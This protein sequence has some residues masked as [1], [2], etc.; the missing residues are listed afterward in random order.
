MKHAKKI[1]TKVATRKT[2]K[3]DAKKLYNALIQKDIDTLEREKSN[4][5]E[6]YNILNI[7]E[8]VGSIFNGAYL[9]YKN[10][11]K[12]TIFSEYCREVLQRKQN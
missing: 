5:F 3:S 4:G 1:W 10:L 7:L 2:T 8:N 9:H 12:E 6:K 11:P